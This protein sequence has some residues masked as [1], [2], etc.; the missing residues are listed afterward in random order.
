MYL[1]ARTVAGV[2]LGVGAAR[3]MVRPVAFVN[4]LSIRIR[5]G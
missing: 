4:P 1:A 2:E 3:D 5:A